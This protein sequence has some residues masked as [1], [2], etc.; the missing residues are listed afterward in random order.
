[1]GDGADHLNDQYDG[2]EGL[3]ACRRCGLEGLHW[4]EVDN[5][6]WRLADDH[7][8]VHSC[9]GKPK[10]ANR[11]ITKDEEL[12]RRRARVIACR[13]PDGEI[14]RTCIHCGTHDVGWMK[15]AEG[16]SVKCRDA[17]C[18]A[19]MQCDDG[20]WTGLLERWN[21]D[22]PSTAD[23]ATCDTAGMSPLDEAAVGVWWHVQRAKAYCR[24]GNDEQAMG[25]ATEAFRELGALVVALKT[26]TPQET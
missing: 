16:C 20:N 10:P 7:D 17:A 19:R 13:G 8:N 5:G 23:P 1:M 22:Y 2:H 11:P 15:T 26:S 18:G 6:R 25:H 21:R 14:I 4:V 3:H 9:T 12:D 24:D